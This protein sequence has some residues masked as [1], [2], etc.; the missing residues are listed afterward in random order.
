MSSIVRARLAVLTVPLLLVCLCAVFAAAP[1]LA[2]DAGNQ[3]QAA[4]AIENRPAQSGT[5]R[6]TPV[7]VIH[8]DLDVTGAAL[9]LRLTEILNESS[10]FRLTDKDEKK[11]KI[12]VSSKEEFPGRPGIASAYSV[13]WIYSASENVLTHYLDSEVGFVAPD[14]TAA[15]ARALA[16]ATDDV[17]SRYAYLFE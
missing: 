14:G 6:V 17:A 5:D 1:A 10:L 11:I 2:Q 13:V 16:T 15:A 8:D 7:A 12:I 3:G 4:T 9:V